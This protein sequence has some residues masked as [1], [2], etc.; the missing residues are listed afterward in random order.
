L[1]SSNKVT[2]Q[3]SKVGLPP[4]ATKNANATRKESNLDDIREKNDTYRIE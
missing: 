3:R 4:L 2:P 1:I